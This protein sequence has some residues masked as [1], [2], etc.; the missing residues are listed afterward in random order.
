MAVTIVSPD[1]ITLDQFRAEVGPEPVAEQ[2]ATQ[3]KTLERLFTMACRLVRDRTVDETPTELSNQAIVML[4][5]YI[6]ARRNVG[7][8]LPS[9]PY[10]WTNSGCQWILR[11][12]LKKPTALIEAV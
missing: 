4:G 12:Y 10:A 2:D 6:Y 7:E 3:Q 11:D 5:G 9:F 1:A 8:N